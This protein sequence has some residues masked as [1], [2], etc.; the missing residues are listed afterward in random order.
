MDRSAR[1]LEI[2]PALALSLALGA[3]GC[4]RHGGARQDSSPSPAA[5]APTLLAASIEAP[6]SSDAGPAPAPAPEAPAPVAAA[7]PVAPSL[8]GK[9]V[10]LVGDSMV[11]GSQGLTRALQQRFEAEGAHFVR[12]YKVS[13]SIVS[14]DKS[15]KL[16]DLV[17]RHH[18]DVILLTLGANDVFVPFP[19]ALT[20]NVQSIAKRMAGDGTPDCYWLG[21]PTWKPDTGIVQVLRDNVAP[22]K[23]F[24]ASALTL[25][26]A[27]DGIHPTDR[28]GAEWAK[29]FW[30]FYRPGDPP[31]P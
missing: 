7:A 23:F 8:A 14:Y 22:C 21:P 24:D 13:E 2:L 19:A 1:T 27:A 25:Q 12:D 31:A 4:A 15:S 3:P 5:P 9:T 30:A 20:G 28:G 11:G 18:P 6:V 17:A 29:S 10:L 26:R 16:K